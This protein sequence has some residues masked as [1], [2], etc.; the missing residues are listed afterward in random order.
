MYVKDESSFEMVKISKQVLDEF[1]DTIV[2]VSI[3]DDFVSPSFLVRTL[4]RWM[5]FWAQ[6]IIVIEP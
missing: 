4:D 6:N 1:Q 2:C 3:W 5:I